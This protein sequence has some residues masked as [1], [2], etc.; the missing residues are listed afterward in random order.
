[1]RTW[2]LECLFHA[3]VRL[4]VRPLRRIVDKGTLASEPEADS[5]SSIS[6]R[7]RERVLCGRRLERGN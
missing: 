5:V 2:R 3:L 4:L 1:M 6:E 7:L